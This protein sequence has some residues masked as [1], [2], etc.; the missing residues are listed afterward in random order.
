MFGDKSGKA[1]EY[2]VVKE[3]LE[4][5]EFIR[6]DGEWYYFKVSSFW[7]GSETVKVKDGAFGW[8]MEKVKF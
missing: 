4:V 6:K 7:N 5:K 1:R 8:R 3:G 2:L